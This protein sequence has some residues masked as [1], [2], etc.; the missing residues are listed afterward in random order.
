MN[1]LDPR[2]PDRFWAKCIPEPNSGCWLWI[3]CTNPV[4]GY[5]QSWNG[6][7]QSYPHRIAYEALV[8]AIGPELEIDHF[9]CS[10][11]ACCNPAHLR[12]VSHRVNTLRSG[13]FVAA[14]ANKIACP[15][16]HPYD[17]ANTRITGGSRVCRTCHRWRTRRK[18]AS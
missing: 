5:G 8:G 4:N 14:N 13:S 10:E 2:L 12:A 18:R 11:R 15:Q 16:G 17:E 9:V 1:F 7:R 3:G 6:K